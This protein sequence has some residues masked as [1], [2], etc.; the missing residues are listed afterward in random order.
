M[1]RTALSCGARVG[2]EVGGGG[3]GGWGGGWNMPSYEASLASVCRSCRH[4][5][6]SQR[7][8]EQLELE[9]FVYEDYSSGSVKPNN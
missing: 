3:G 6:S 7:A 8:R 1:P 2:D 9:H 5:V 4:P